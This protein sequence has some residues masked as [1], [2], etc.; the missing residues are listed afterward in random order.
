MRGIAPIDGCVSYSDI[1]NYNTISHAS[2][3]LERLEPS[4]TGRFRQFWLRIRANI[5]NVS[6]RLILDKSPFPAAIS[7]K[8]SPDMTKRIG[9]VPLRCAKRTSLPFTHTHTRAHARAPAIELLGIPSVRLRHLERGYRTCLQL[10]VKDL[11]AFLLGAL[12]KAQLITDFS[13]SV[14]IQQT[15][16]HT[17]ADSPGC[18]GNVQSRC[19]GK[20]ASLRQ[21]ESTFTR[22]LDRDVKAPAKNSYAPDNRTLG[23]VDLS[24]RVFGNTILVSRC[25]PP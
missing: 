20:T 21:L 10:R 14:K 17:A 3:F 6:M 18:S 22:C 5:E 25:V 11:D 19:F 13:A 9:P 1:V 2:F 15:L 4:K 23:P 16:P 8:K 12:L 7:A 24:V